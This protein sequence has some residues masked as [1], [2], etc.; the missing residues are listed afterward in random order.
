M[1]V[2]GIVVGYLKENGFDG[3]CGDE[4]GCGIDDLAPCECDAIMECK[5]AYKTPCKG[6][7]CD[8]PCDGYDEENIGDCYSTRKPDGR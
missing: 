6:A 5:P 3:L 8:H 4:C 7:A 1:T 2:K